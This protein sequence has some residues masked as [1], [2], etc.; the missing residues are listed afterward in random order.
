MVVK[1]LEYGLKKPPRLLEN[2]ERYLS[3]HTFELINEDEF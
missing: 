2:L 1:T 3:D